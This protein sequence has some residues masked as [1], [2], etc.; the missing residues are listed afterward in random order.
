MTANVPAF[1][2]KKT[3]FTDRS[4]VSEHEAENAKY[5]MDKYGK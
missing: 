2:K 5:K 1:C 4:K 3:P